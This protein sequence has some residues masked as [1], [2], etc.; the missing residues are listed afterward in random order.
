MNNSPA[1]SASQPALNKDRVEARLL[2]FPPLAEQRRI[3]PEVEGRLSVL[4]ELEIVVFAD[5]Q[6]ATR[7]RQSILK[8]AFSET[9]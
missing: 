5:F 7:L 6:R 2:T 3:V 4:E 9:L 1:D 8:R